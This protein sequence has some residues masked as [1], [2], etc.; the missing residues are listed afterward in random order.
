[1]V[2]RSFVAH[3]L[4][5]NLPVKELAAFYPEA[6]RTDVARDRRLFLLEAAIV[7]LIV[8]E[9]VLGFLR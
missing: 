7:V 8:L 9:I 3:A 5:E 1:M 6:E 2:M 4:A